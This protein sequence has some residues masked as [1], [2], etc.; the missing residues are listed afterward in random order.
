MSKNFQQLVRQE[1]AKARKHHGPQASYHE[2]YAILIEEIDELW[3]IVKQK[4]TV[5]NHEN[6]LAELVQ[7]ASCAQKMAEDVVIPNLKKK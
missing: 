2:G 6:T 4:S 1:L 5:R 7:I 3:E